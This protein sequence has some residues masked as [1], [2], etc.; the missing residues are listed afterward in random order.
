LREKIER[1]W[2]LAYSKDAMPRSKVVSTQFGLG[3]VAEEMGRAISWADFA[4]ET[5]TSQRLKYQKR[6]TKA[7]AT[8]KDAKKL[9]ECTRT[10]KQEGDSECE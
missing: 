5:N 9:A 4:E 6:V 10:V 3:I 1:I 2:K 7:V 8:L